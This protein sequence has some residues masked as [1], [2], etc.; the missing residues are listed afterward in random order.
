MDDVER[1]LERAITDLLA[2]RR[3]G[4]TI[5]PSDA[6]RAV[7]TEA[8]IGPGTGTGQVPGAGTGRQV[9]GTATGAGQPTRTATAGAS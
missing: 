1:R 4:A 2:R 9:P 3:A 5:C 8:G 7:W 6:A